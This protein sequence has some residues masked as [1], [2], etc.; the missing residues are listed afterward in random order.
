MTVPDFGGLS[1]AVVGDLIADLD[2]VTEP[3][4]LSREAPVMVLRHASEQVGAGGA[5]NVARNL[6][7]LGART[8]VLGAVGRDARGRELVQILEEEGIIVFAACIRVFLIIEHIHFLF[9]KLDSHFINH[10]SR[11]GMKSDMV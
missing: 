7:T 9:L 11:R 10:F 8:S 1:V 4:G 5:A 2:V 3:R 6:R